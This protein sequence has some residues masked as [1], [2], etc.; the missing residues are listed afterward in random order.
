MYD[1][2]A[3]ERAYRRACAE[4]DRRR[5]QGDEQEPPR[6]EQEPRPRRRRPRPADDQ[7]PRGDPV[8]HGTAAHLPAAPRPA[9]ARRGAGGA[10]GRPGDRG[11]HQL[12]GHRLLAGQR[13][14][15][16]W[17]RGGVDGRTVRAP[18]GE[19]RRR[20]RYGDAE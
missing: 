5:R 11:G 17:P 13:D 6:Q 10:G 16:P 2:P 12:A 1:D 4:L 20:V 15:G 7:G 14:R 9:G 3:E 19:G 18:G 8:R